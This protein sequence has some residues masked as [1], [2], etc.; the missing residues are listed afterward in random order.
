[1][2]FLTAT[3]LSVQH[4]LADAYLFVLA[5]LGYSLALCGYA[6]RRFRQ[7]P[8][9]RHMV[10]KQ[11]VAAHIVGMIGSYTVLCWTPG[12]ARSWP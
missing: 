1:M 5:T 2:V 3:I 9:V 4:W 8:M 11:W 7:E 10:G 6:A 12:C